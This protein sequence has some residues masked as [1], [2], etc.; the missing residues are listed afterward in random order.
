MNGKKFFALPAL[1]VFLGMGIVSAQT[2]VTDLYV[3]NAGFESCAATASSVN[4]A[5]GHTAVDYT[6]SGW[7]MT[8]TLNASSTSWSTGAVFAYGGNAQLNGATVPAADN[9]GNGGKALGISVGRNNAVYYRSAT[10]VTLPAGNYTLTVNAYNAHTATLFYSLVG[11]VATDGSSFLSTKEQFASKTWVQDAVSFTLYSDTEGQ[12]QIGGRS[13]TEALGSG[14]HAKILFDNITLAYSE[15]TAEQKELSIPHWEDPQFFGENKLE[16]HATFM[17]YASTADMKADARYEKPWLTP[18]RASFLSLNGTWKFHFVSRPADRP[19]MSTFFGDEADVAAWDD[20]DVPSCWEMK[21]YDKPVYANVNYPFEDNPPVIKLRSEFSG[22]L[23]ENPVGSYRREFVLPEGWNEKRVVL[24]FDGV[25]GA[26]YVWVNG[27]YVGYSQGANNDAEFDLTGIVRTGANNISVQVVRYNDGSYLEGQDAWHMSG[28][29]RD[30][31]LYATPKTYVADHVITADLEAGNGYRSGTLNVQIAMGTIEATASAKTIEVELLDADG[32][33]VKST[34]AEVSS[35]SS[36]LHSQLSGL[37]D[38]RLW[39]AEDP[40]LYTVIV[41]QKGGNGM[42]EMVFSTRYGFRQIEQRGQLVYINGQR[43]YFKGVNTQDTHPVT[44]RTM[45]VETMLQDIVMMKKANMNTVRCSHYPRQ[46]KMMA[47][48]DYYGMYV[49]DEADIESHKNWLDNGPSGTLASATN[50]KNQYIDRTVRMVQRDRN[51]PCVVFWSL[52]NEGGVGENFQASYHA[53]RTLDD[54][55]IHYEGHRTDGTFNDITD[56][57]SSMYPSLDFVSEHVNGPKPYFVCEYV[58]SKGAGLG[59]MQEYW[60]L[61]EGSSAGLGACI[62]DWV[63]QAIF[64]PADLD[65][66]DPDD[67]STWP[68]QNGFLKLMAG[69]DFPGPDQ[70]DVTG[71][72]NDGIITADRSWSAELNVAKHI[73]QFVRFESYEAPSKTVTVKNAYNFLDLRLFTLHYEVLGDGVVV[74]QGNVD[75]PS[76]LPG[77][78]ASVVLPLTTALDG[79]SETL[80]N[81]EA[82][83][84]SAT[85][86]AEAGYTMAWEQFVLQHRADGLPSVPSAPTQLQLDETDNAYTITGSN[87]SMTVGKDG[88]VTAMQIHG[89]NIMT[90]DGAPTYSN[91]RYISHDPQGERDNG[92]TSTTVNCQMAADGQTATVTLASSGTRCAT[93]LVYTVYAAGVVDLQATFTPQ[94]NSLV[95][96]N[97]K[98][99]LRRMGLKL[100]MPAGRDQVEYYAQGPWESFV[101]RQSGNVLGVYTTTVDEMFEPYSHPQ[102]CG[103]RM[104]L[105]RLKLWGDDVATAGTL[106]ITTQGQVDFS[107]MHYD[108]ET[109]A[110]DKLH[111]WELTAERPVYAR[112]DAYQ[113][114]IGDATFNLGVL[115]KYRCPSTPLSYTL[116]FEMVGAEEENE[117]RSDLRQLIE[118]AEV[119]AVPTENVG[120]GAFQFSETNIATFQS[121]VNSAKEVYDDAEATDAELEEAKSDLQAAVSTYNS[122]KD[123]LNEPTAE[124]YTLQFHTANHANDG[125]F[126]TMHKGTNPT[127]GNYGA[128]YYTPAANVN[129]TQAFRLTKTTGMNRYTL[130]YTT[131]EGTT[132]Y[133]CN[134]KV[135]EPDNNADWIPRR[136]RTT[137]TEAKAL[138][139]EIR[140]KEMSGGDARFQLVNT[141]VDEGVGQNNNDDMYT[142]NA[143]TFSFAEAQQANVPVA[144]ANNV[145]F[146]TRMFPFVPVLPVGVKAYA[147]S[148]TTTK[149]DNDYLVLDEVNVPA[150]NTPYILYAPNGCDSEP[151]NGW[152]TAMTSAYSAGFLTGIYEEGLAPTGSYVLQNHSI[153]G[154]G[155]YAVGENRPTVAAYRAYLTT[156]SSARALFCDLDEAVGVRAVEMVG[157]IQT[158][159]NAAGTRMKALVKGLNIVVN[160][161]GTV[162]KV[163]VR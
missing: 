97:G 13:M 23:G 37:T 163:L 9:A 131:E 2:D 83:L 41:R 86:W 95:I 150:A 88:T 145:R 45:G 26:S 47:M 110:T 64:A 31:Y 52:G 114:G 161:N 74:E 132:R 40:Q 73:H 5:G 117:A 100:K 8:S 153:D 89:R 70:S 103:N 111:P 76:T 138:P 67:P 94:D 119:I 1:L 125:W 105:R 113:R 128:K 10:A 29:H 38:L 126:V 63:D 92:I 82:R 93:T 156:P 136:I 69:Y 61:I 135:W 54:R 102:T 109:F 27:Q 25:Y 77:A 108:E 46:A 104:S 42:E 121:A 28:I 17:P 85:P 3:V 62:W 123:E 32:T 6:S 75:L 142:Q 155:F 59:N 141:S 58:H 57:Y 87:V 34:S 4:A 60:D 71:S 21:G 147:C 14:D 65:G 68:R 50:Y 157:G 99:T 22:Q 79:S 107:L 53:V 124:R 130:S 43:V 91:Y 144:I 160:A 112:F 98:C 148:G 39:S 78:T 80:L 44:G 30:V 127:Q 120:E 72:L 49:M 149:A 24:H 129:Y 116:R 154:V 18:G 139:F 81:V 137:D 115:D 134:G 16:G 151:L 20:I 84:K 7:K 96:Q 36:I 56:I 162:K 66:A 55:L 140:F 158:L 122:V 48:F 101:D 143:A 146:A 12:F 51:N 33:L 19:G 159:Y 118:E 90:T 152:G 11:F 15:L 35:Q 133:L 106:V